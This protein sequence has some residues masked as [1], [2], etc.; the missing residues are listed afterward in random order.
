MSLAQTLICNM[1]LRTGRAPLQIVEATTPVPKRVVAPGA[2]IRT[3]CA[4]VVRGKPPSLHLILSVLRL[5]RSHHR[6]ACRYHS[7]VD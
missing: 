5:A 1:L 3:G 7:R 4:V 2:V 6:I